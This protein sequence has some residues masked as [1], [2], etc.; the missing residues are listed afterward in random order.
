MTKYGPVLRSFALIIAAVLPAS[1]IVPARA[2]SVRSHAAVSASQRLLPA[3]GF[4]VNRGQAAAPVRFLVRGGNRTLCLT[5]DGIILRSSGVRLSIVRLQFAAKE[6]RLRITAYAPLPAHVSYFLGHGRRSWYTNI[7]TYAR[8]EYHDL[9]PGIDLRLDRQAGGIRDEWLLHPG[10]RLDEIRMTLSDSS[11]LGPVSHSQRGLLGGGLVY[12]WASRMRRVT[13]ARLVVHHRGVVTLKLVPRASR[14][15]QADFRLDYSTYLGGSSFDFATSVAIDVAGSTYV[16]GATAS[17]D[18]PTMRGIVR[19]LHGGGDAEDAFLARLSPTGALL[20]ATYLGGSGDDEATG[21]AVEGRSVYVT[22]FT[23]SADFPTVGP[24]PDSA[25]GSCGRNA[26]AGGA[27]FVAKLNPSG[28]ALTFSTCLGHQGTSWAGGIAVRHGRVYVVGSTTAQD[29]PIV[30]AVQ[31]RKAVGTDAFVAELNRRGNRLLY[32]S[33]LGGEGDEQGA[34]IA[35][36]AAGNVYVSGSTNSTHFP[37]RHAIQSRFGG[38]SGGTGTGDAFITKFSPSGR[39]VY[40]TYLG[41]SMDDEVTAVAADAAGNAYVTGITESSDFPT[42]R[43]LQPSNRGGADV[44]VAKIDPAGT[45]LVY[46]TYL[47]GS[48]NDGG[49]G[50]A[51]DKQGNVYVTGST[52]SPN[53]PLVHPFAATYSGGVYYGDAFVAQLNPAGDALRFS[54]Y[55]GGRADDVG[56]GIAVGRAGAID[57]AGGTSSGDFPVKDALSKQP[58]L[59]GNAWVTRIVRTGG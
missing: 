38:G 27:A 18:F 9:Y 35:V 1:F 34:S 37:T 43:A 32:S 40:S 4:E 44:F 15:F 19:S 55:L 57:V 45:S 2:A 53:F 46:S 26:A 52:A 7:P 20:Y 11:R 47:G 22:G 14:A 8:V 16:V 12:H 13:P 36:D 6:G 25:D 56:M 21:V 58:P 5:A 24:L 54:T 33:Y 51:T 59:R 28:T 48:G 50:I 23:R 39:I 10:A 3:L 41:G 29:F 42:A 17:P 49:H 31:R 30:R